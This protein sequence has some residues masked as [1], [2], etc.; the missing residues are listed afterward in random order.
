M[1]ERNA[2]QL[3]RRSET[4]GIMVGSSQIMKQVSEKKRVKAGDSA[5]YAA[6]TSRIPTIPKRASQK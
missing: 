1:R 3:H 6:T 4:N 2:V 5:S